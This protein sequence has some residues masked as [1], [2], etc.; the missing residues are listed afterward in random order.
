MWMRLALQSGRAQ[1]GG[2]IAG[3][4]IVRRSTVGEVQEEM[5]VGGVME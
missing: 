1:C 5:K 4:G 3:V 2:M